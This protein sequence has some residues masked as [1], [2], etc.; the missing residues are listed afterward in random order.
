MKGL[1]PCADSIVGGTRIPDQTI[2]RTV[3]FEYKDDILVSA[4]SGVSADLEWDCL[5]LQLPIPEMP[6]LICK[7]KST[8]T[9]WLYRDLSDANTLGVSLPSLNYAK[10]R[11]NQLSTPWRAETEG[12]TLGQI[13][14]AFR[15]TF[16]GVSVVFD[17]PDLHNEGR[18]YSGNIRTEITTA[19]VEIVDE[20]GTTSTYNHPSYIIDK[21]PVDERALISVCPEMMRAKAREGAYLPARFMNQAHDYSKCSWEPIAHGDLVA[22]TRFLGNVEVGFLDADSTIPS[23]GGQQQLVNPGGHAVAI[24]GTDNTQLGVMLFKGLSGAANLDIKMRMGL[25]FAASPGSPAAPAM[26]DAPTADAKA[27]E[28]FFLIQHKLDTAYPERY[29]SL[30]ALIPLIGQAVS[31]LAGWAIPKA[32]NWVSNSL[33][34]RR[35]PV[36]IP[37]D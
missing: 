13:C 18:V 35:K 33:K 34:P 21:I 9:A 6:Y 22:K 10:V 28:D 30:G 1:D 12:A 25:E 20:S 2:G 36:D 37:V 17:A 4:P 23:W 27:L 5:I 24:S 31:A 11:S 16:K 32:A 14:T 29:N 19:Q 15:T 8:D 3:A 26:A 7:K